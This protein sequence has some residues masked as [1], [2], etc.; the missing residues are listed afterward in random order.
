[1]LL[2]RFFKKD[3]IKKLKE[4]LIFLIKTFT[5]FHKIFTLYIRV[6]NPI[7]NFNIA[8]LISYIF[9]CSIHWNSSN[10]LLLIVSFVVSYV[11]NLGATTLGLSAH[12][13]RAN[14]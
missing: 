3:N 14:V 10:N 4:K 6:T 7:R 8:Y 11:Y 2:I 12:V 9:K 1:M 13:E 5:Y